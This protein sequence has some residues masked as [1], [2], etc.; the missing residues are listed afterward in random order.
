MFLVFKKIKKCWKKLE[1]QIKF[2]ELSTNSALS[3]LIWH[4]SFKKFGLRVKSLRKP[5]RRQ[6]MLRKWLLK[7]RLRKLRQHCSEFMKSKLN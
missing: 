1:N 5:P 2:W 3:L 7:E 4:Q 6:N